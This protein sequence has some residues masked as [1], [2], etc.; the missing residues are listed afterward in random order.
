MVNLKEPN[1]ENN[2]DGSYGTC[3]FGRDGRMG[4]LLARSR[5]EDQQ[6][7][8]AH[9]WGVGEGGGM[10]KWFFGILCLWTA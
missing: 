5:K 4:G 7:E 3:G 6:F 10:A 8:I 9:R 2:K 1:N